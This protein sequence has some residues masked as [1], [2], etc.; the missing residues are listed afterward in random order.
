MHRYVLAVLVTLGCQASGCSSEKSEPSPATP[1]PASAPE[2]APR[3]TERAFAAS[4]SFAPTPKP[5]P[6]DWLAEFE[7]PGQTFEHYLQARPNKPSETRK[8]LYILPIASRDDADW[9]QGGRL[10]PIELMARYAELFFQ[11]PV[12]VLPEVTAKATRAKTRINRH[13][14]KPQLLT[15]DLLRYLEGQLPADAYALIGLTAIDLYPEAS[16]N[17]VFGQAHLRNRVG[18]HSLARY[19]PSF[20][21]KRARGPKAR[22]LVL[23]RSLKVLAHE[24]GHMFGIEHCTFFHCTMNGSNHL[25]ETDAQPM[26]VCPVDLR[27]LHHA[28]GFDPVARYRALG[29][30]YGKHGL[31]E[32][33][34][35]IA[36]RQRELTAS[37]AP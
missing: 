2:P 10:P 13:T 25:D 24:L 29:D 23:R 19:H 6:G 28:I 30:F 22:A 4:D 1:A 21:G 15:S 18:I 37:S 33:A 11:L 16:W 20:Y 5:A 17:F 7:E 9:S 34:G 36:K 14:G 3:A 27:K 32:E 31:D 8:T 35:W 26:H 12:A